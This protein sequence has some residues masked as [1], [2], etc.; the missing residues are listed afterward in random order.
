M[1]HG[2]YAPKDKDEIMNDTLL[3]IA[4]FTCTYLCSIAFAIMLTR[5]MFPFKT[6][7]EMAAAPIKRSAAQQRHVRKRTQ[8]ILPLLHSRAVG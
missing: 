7:E 6:K 8:I 3:V 2:F 4:T 1:W 5:L